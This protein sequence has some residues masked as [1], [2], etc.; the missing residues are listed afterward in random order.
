MTYSQHTETSLDTLLPA[1]FDTSC[2]TAAGENFY[3]NRRRR[4]NFYPQ[5]VTEPQKNTPV[6]DQH[7]SE[8]T[9]Y[10]YTGGNPVNWV[11]PSGL[12]T[13]SVTLNYPLDGPAYPQLKLKLTGP[14]AV[15]E[16]GV[17][18][19][20]YFLTENPPLATVCVIGTSVSCTYAADPTW[21]FIKK[22]GKEASN[23]P[24]TQIC[25]PA[26]PNGNIPVLIFPPGPY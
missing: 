23:A 5:P 18:K 1:L 24:Q 19:P 21:K 12:E 15:C 3:Q 11:D 4:R 16:L 10:A 26:H 20:C 2:K 9:I 14:E 13:P 25:T 7:A 6:Y 22:V 17:S 8:P